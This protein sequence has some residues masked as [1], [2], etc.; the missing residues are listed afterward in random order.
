M[1]NY[2]LFFL[3]FHNSSF[4]FGQLACSGLDNGC[5]RIRALYIPVRLRAILGAKRSYSCSSDCLFCQLL[6][7]IYDESKIALCNRLVRDS[8]MRCFSG[9]QICSIFCWSISYLE[10]SQPI[11]QVEPLKQRFWYN[12]LDYICNFVTK[13][14]RESF[15]ISHRQSYILNQRTRLPRWNRGINSLFDYFGISVY[16]VSSIFI[17]YCSKS[18][19]RIN[20]KLRNSDSACSICFRQFY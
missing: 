5:G 4:P 7:N 19:H 2:Y 18:L 8:S 9:L 3:D 1:L 12:N 11:T 20:S 10:P 15:I 13:H 6:G 17:W 14:Q 16:F